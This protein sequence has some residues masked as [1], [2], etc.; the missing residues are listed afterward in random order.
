[1][2]ETYTRIR[3]ELKTAEE[4]RDRVRDGAAKHRLSE[5]CKALRPEAHEVLQIVHAQAVG[6]KLEAQARDRERQALDRAEFNMSL[7]SAITDFLPK[8]VRV[9]CAGEVVR[10][11]LG[12]TRKPSRL[13]FFLILIGVCK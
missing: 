1:M 10:R 11:K 2:E 3:L 9:W 13:E 12:V 4:M 5:R 8:R 7:H 6:V